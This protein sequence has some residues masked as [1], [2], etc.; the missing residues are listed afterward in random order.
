MSNA[1]PSEVTP[2]DLDTATDDH[3]VRP[4]L[5][6]C[7]SFVAGDDAALSQWEDSEKL[8]GG[9]GATSRLRKEDQEVTSTSTEPSAT[10][11]TSS[12]SAAYA[13]MPLI[14]GDSHHPPGLA[15]TAVEESD[16][17]VKE[18]Q[19]DSRPSHA[20]VEVDEPLRVNK[21]Q[22]G[23]QDIYLPSQD[24]QIAVVYL[25]RSASAY[26][27]FIFG[28]IATLGLLPLV[29]CFWVPRLYRKWVYR[30]RS[31]PTEQELERGDR[32]WCLVKIPSEEASVQPLVAR[33]LPISVPARSVFTPNMR[34]PYA[35]TLQVQQGVTREPLAVDDA[36]AQLS[37][38]HILDFRHTPLA[39]HPASRKLAYLPEWRDVNLAQPLTPSEA[40]FRQAIFGDNIIDVKGQSLASLIVSECLHPFYIFTLASC[41][42]WFYDTYQVYAAVVLAISILGIGMTVVQTRRSQNKLR[43]MSRHELSVDVFRAFGDDDASSEKCTA[44]GAASWQSKSSSELVPGDI[45]SLA[46][47]LA[48]SLPADMLL[49]QG[50]SCIVNESMLTGESTPSSKNPIPKT[51]LAQYARG[52]IGFKDVEK[53][54]LWGGTTLLRANTEDSDDAD[55][56]TAVVISTAWNSSK[57]S[58]VKMM[59]FPRPIDFAFYKDAFMFICVLVI[60]ACLGFIGSVIN[61]V[62]VGVDGGEIGLR[63][64]DLFTI[65]VPP[66][67][68]AAMSLC[69]TF[70]LS[71]LKRGAIYCISPQRINVAGKVSIAVFDKTGTLTETGLDVRGVRIPASEHGSNF[72]EL[73][74]CIENV[75]GG[76]GMV[77][78]MAVTHDLNLIDDEPLGDPLEVSMLLFTKWNLEKK[79]RSIQGGEA[80][81][82]VQCVS[83]PSADRS[84]GVLRR[85]DFSPALRRM[86]VLVQREGTAFTTAY[87]KGAP[88]SVVPLCDPASIPD[89]F[90]AIYNDATRKGLRVL[91]FAQKTASLSWDGVQRC[92][93]GF[94]ESNLEFVGLLFFENKLKT[95]SSAAISELHE[96]DIPTKMCTGDA[97][98][99]AIAVAREAGIVPLG[100]PVFVP[101]LP[102]TFK[103]DGSSGGM[104]KPAEISWSD[105]DLPTTAD[106]GAASGLDPYS[107][108]PRDPSL[109][110]SMVGL[111]LTG[112]VFEHLL[113][114]ASDETLARLLV[115]AQVFARFSPELKAEL[116]ERLHKIGHTVAF[117]G[118]G[119]NDTGALKGAD[120]GLSLSDA[121]ASIAAPFTSGN[122]DIA[123][124]V[125][126]I[127]E[128]RNCLAT[129]TSLFLYF[130]VYAITEYYSVIL[131]YGQTASWNNADYLYVDIFMV[132]SIAIG[133]AYGKPASQLSKQRPFSRLLTRRIMLSLA[134]S[135]VLLIVA[136]TVPYVVLHKQPWYDQP[137]FQPDDLSLENHDNTVVAKTAFFTFTIASI[138]WSIGPPHRQPLHRNYLLLTAIVVLG[139]I[140]LAALFSN[141]E[142][143]GLVKL[144]TFEILPT[145]FLFIIFGTILI[146]A[147]LAFAW[148]F[149]LV[150]VCA[151]ALAGPSRKWRSWRIRGD[152]VDVEKKYRSVQR[153]LDREEALKNKQH[154]ELQ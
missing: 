27:L 49:L 3:L 153:A 2:P 95:T 148:E 126:L 54:L 110:L 8:R 121:E 46:P 123:S 143:N 101:R 36:A 138:A 104:S 14:P 87:V 98:N 66:A 11:T 18:E 89:D 139:V 97:V 154:R 9:R 58:L 146:Q 68:P 103:G 108:S 31:A 39:Y 29:A 67:L 100:Q 53:Y 137:E 81:G 93:R 152:D 92:S 23:R 56:V 65:C 34:I 99:T 43:N 116:V 147:A 96:A 86:S 70:A 106:E 151:R 74:T 145:R 59:L 37:K 84:V 41:G 140:N 149:Y 142:G 55:K 47:L 131:L 134:G 62:R 91:A 64:I 16:E 57:G 120:V 127:K 144:F 12:D 33:S 22:N 125:H 94:V 44:S 77:E 112:N 133:M 128:G 72:S 63:T 109:S 118:D 32:V 82:R 88:E 135:L 24:L 115:R 7:F 85:F 105:I 69:T 113:L 61:F 75:A 76:C 129:S 102:D 141:T 48:Q 132:F 40:A 124:V 150:D 4:P 107:L 60:I 111:A 73:L 13:T 122:D 51:I 45:V 28:S 83:S 78:A 79:Q 50:S 17:D 25:R 90:D 26:I 20:V 130:G 21:G 71:R 117:I 5:K 15:P 6:A 136:I 80:M 10:T 42:L 114:H 35:S 38:I 119:A 19:S 1:S 30:A 52:E